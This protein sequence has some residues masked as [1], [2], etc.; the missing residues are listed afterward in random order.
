MSSVW[1]SK[2]FTLVLQTIW[3][4]IKGSSFFLSGLINLI[5]MHR[6]VRIHLENQSMRSSSTSRIF[7]ALQLPFSSTLCM[8]LSERVQ[9]LSVD[10]LSVSARV[11]QLLFL[12]ASGSTFRTMMHLHSLWSHGR[13]TLGMWLTPCTRKL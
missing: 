2:I 6:L 1:T 13:G 11:S 7:S 5:M 3:N 12:M 10:T 9:I 4:R 8:I